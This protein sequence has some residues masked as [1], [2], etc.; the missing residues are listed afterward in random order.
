MMA[1]AFGYISYLCV[2]Q[3]VLSKLHSKP[4]SRDFLAL[5]FSSNIDNLIIV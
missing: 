2:E 5:I 4:V 3:D 1:F